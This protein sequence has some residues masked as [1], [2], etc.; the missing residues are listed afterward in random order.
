M[1]DF[2]VGKNLVLVIYAYLLQFVWFLY[3]P[4][5]RWQII[6]SFFSDSISEDI[7]LSSLSKYVLGCPCFFMI[8]GSLLLE[9]TIC[10]KDILFKYVKKIVIILLVF[11]T[12]FSFIKQFAQ[13]KTFSIVLI[14]TRYFLFWK[15]RV[16]GIYGTCM[17]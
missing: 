17:F 10:Y 14:K 1:N 16:L 7:F 8:T 15:I 9:R 11:G 4:V 13:N 12:T 3:I 6:W 2:I 5:V